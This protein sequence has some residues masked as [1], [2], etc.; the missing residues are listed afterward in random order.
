MSDD[1]LDQLC[2]KLG[3]HFKDGGV[4]VEAL[5]HSRVYLHKGT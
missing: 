4:L 3:Y 5:T 2:F 1:K